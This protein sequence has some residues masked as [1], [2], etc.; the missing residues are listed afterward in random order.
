[1]VLK[2]LEVED[3]GKVLGKERKGF[4]NEI[5]WNLQ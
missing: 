4:I 2:N 3:C 1:M 5:Q